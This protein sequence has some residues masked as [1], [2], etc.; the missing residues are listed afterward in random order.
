MGI[1]H[2][3]VA[4]ASEVTRSQLAVPS[5][6]E[7]VRTPEGTVSG[8]AFYAA[9]TAT[10]RTDAGGV[11]F[12]MG[13][14]AWLKEKLGTV[15]E[16]S[17]LR[18]ITVTAEGGFG[19]PIRSDYAGVEAVFNELDLGDILP[20][21][22]WGSAQ[23][24]GVTLFG[25]RFTY[26]LA[27]LAP[28]EV[29]IAAQLGR[30]GTQ[31]STNTSSHMLH[32]VARMAEGGAL[33][34]D[35]TL[36]YAQSCRV[37]GGD[38]HW[39]TAA[40]SS[41]PAGYH[42][43]AFYAGAEGLVLG[44][45]GPLFTMP[46]YGFGS[47]SSSSWSNNAG[48]GML[49]LTEYM[50]TLAGAGSSRGVAMVCGGGYEATGSGVSSVSILEMPSMATVYGVHNFGWNPRAQCVG[51]SSTGEPPFIE[52]RDIYIHQ[53]G[54]IYG[55]F[56]LPHLRYKTRSVLTERRPLMWGSTVLT[57]TGSRYFVES[58]MFTDN[59]GRYSG[60]SAGYLANSLVIAFEVAD[61]VTLVQS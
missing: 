33:H 47:S 44:F 24:L 51:A 10:S 48:G 37:L 49:Y 25:L 1:L 20:R 30:V 34:T 45:G 38:T 26:T 57:D 22:S 4:T 55:H 3:F 9:M 58:L 41:L 15:P 60:S 36:L 52:L 6:A 2:A 17:N 28:V 13:N 43:V 19:A 14:F 46:A 40:S 5:S 54:A 16:I 35:D 27:G 8:A 39:N 7:F 21:A 61:E 11:R 53:T 31:A 29:E 59:N 56:H 12:Q 23:Y 18:D 50:D 42:R 32:V